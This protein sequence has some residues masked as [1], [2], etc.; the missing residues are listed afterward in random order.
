MENC[1]QG[2]FKSAPNLLL[3]LCAY[4]ATAVTTNQ[5]TQ[6][7]IQ[8]GSVQQAAPLLEVQ[9]NKAL[10]NVATNLG[11]AFNSNCWKAESQCKSDLTGPKRTEMEVKLKI[12][13][14][15]SK[16]KCIWKF[17]TSLSQLLQTSSTVHRC[18]QN[19][20]IFSAPLLNIVALSKP[21]FQTL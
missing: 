2:F 4:M 12:D 8:I 6:L 1:L 7:T 3:C 13:V 20:I 19:S 21:I 17:C 18:R 16:E 14:W 11:S 15:Q 5:P 9:L 10:W